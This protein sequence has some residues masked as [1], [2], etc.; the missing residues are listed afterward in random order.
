[1]LT[2]VIVSVG[3]GVL[4]GILD[5]VING[6]PLARRLNEVYKPIARTE[7]NLPAGIAL[8]LAYGFAMAGIFLLIWQSL[9]G[10]TGILKGLCFGLLAW[11]FRVVMSTAS[12]WMMFRI[13]AAT[14]LYGLATGL[15]EML[16]F[17]V[18]YGLTLRPLA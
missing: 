5:G 17:G 6:N 7:L 15:A 16:A 8:D 14:L 2:Y 10:A 4:F 12:Q 1:M 9:P 13:P 18:L 11:F 3:S